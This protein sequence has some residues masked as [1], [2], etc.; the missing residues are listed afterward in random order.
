MKRT[1]FKRPERA[2][3]TAP[4]MTAI[5]RTAAY[6]TPA[7]MTARPKR[8]YVRSEKLREA[9]RLI[10][11][12][13]CDTDDGTVCCAHSNWAEH[14]K[15]KAIKAD[16]NRAASLCSTCHAWLDQG[17]ADGAAKR[18]MWDAAHR[19]TIAALTRLG[20]WPKGVPVPELEEA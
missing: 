15:G 11:C 4:R 16:D 1:P 10:P 20:Y 2:P 13:H 3:R 18:R 8:E 7:V 5:T 12:Q 6:A 9:Y 19:K 14:G 17:A